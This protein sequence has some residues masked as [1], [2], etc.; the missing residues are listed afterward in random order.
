MNNLKKIVY[1]RYV[2]VG[3]RSELLNSKLWL[4]VIIYIGKDIIY[5][6]L[7]RKIKIY[8]IIRMFYI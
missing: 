7:W 8:Y 4:I 5:V 2:L 3:I 6:Y 1:V